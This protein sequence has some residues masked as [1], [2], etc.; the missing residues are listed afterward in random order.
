MPRSA[1][2][3]AEL[4]TEH[5]NEPLDVDVNEPR[6]SWQIPGVAQQH[7]YQIAIAS[8]PSLISVGRADVW[9]SGRVVSASQTD[10]SYRGRALESDAS[11]F[12]AV[13]IWTT[14]GNAPG[15]WSAPVRFETGLLSASD[16]TAK[17]IGRSNPEVVPALGQQSPAPLL[18]KEFMLDDVV[19]R[20]RLRIVGLGYYVAYINGERIGD[21]VLD[22]PPTTFNETALYATHDV[23]DIVHHGENVLAVTLGRGYFGAPR[24]TDVVDLASAP[25]WSEPRL[26]AQ[27]DVTYANGS[28]AR[29]LSDG[30]WRMADGPSSDSARVGERYDARLAP[31][32]WT[33]LGFDASGWM[34][35]PEQPAPTRNVR[36]VAMEPIRIA[37]TLEPVASSSPKPGVTVYDFGRMIAGWALITTTGEAGT[38]ITLK[39]GETLKADGTV[40]LFLNHHVDA[41]TL[42]GSGVETW[43]PSFTRHGFRYI[44][45]STAPVSFGIQ[46]RVNHTDLRPSGEFHSGSDTLNQL[47]A[48]QRAS[49][50]ANMWGFPTD[51]P[52]RDRMGWTADAWL[53]LDSALFNFDVQ[54]LYAQWLRSYRDSQGADG[55]LPMVVPAPA[56]DAFSGP[57][58]PSWSGT[59]VLDAWA[60]YQHYGDTQVLTDNYD[61]MVRWVDL[62]ATIVAAT[63]NIYRGFSFGDWASP[64]T[65]ES[66][67]PFFNA[68]EGVALTASADLYQEARTLA[69]IANVLDRQ[70]DVAKYNAFADEIKAA[71]NATFFDADANVYRTEV[72][73]GYRQTSNLMPLAYGL[74]PAGHEDAVYGN[75]V[76]D[77]RARDNHLNTGAI[78]TKQLLPVL[79]EHGDVDLAYT[80]AT[81]TTYPSWG[82]WLTQG[83]TS[84]WETWSHQ[85]SLQSENHAFLGT[86]DDWLYRYLAGIQAT[87]PG[88]ATV[89]I[90]PVV[91]A[92]LADA[93]ASLSTPRGEVT[94]AWRRTEQGLELAVTI[95]GNTSAEIHVPAGPDDNVVVEGTGHADL[96]RR[97]EGYAVFDSGAGNF[98]FKG[99]R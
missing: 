50:I 61:A 21:R 48:N 17:W 80:L 1:A 13:R 43:E 52:W 26:L 34:P 9:D 71:F 86:F 35:A 68:P 54:R 28:T 36:A 56:L 20:A 63:G 99:S 7:A 44:E 75:L 85:G 40:A 89:R 64:G 72:E 77:I 39:Y 58:D 10:V 82:Y 27:L 59:I 19:A 6:L 32:G 57:N 29:I 23:T 38:M 51:T 76:A 16:W 4:T 15:P 37:E 25:W 12:W 2:Q 95:P 8:D 55:S 47:H 98:T 96:R 60:L 83:A 65:E 53:F 67:L 81:Q 93:S 41:Y 74:V 88:Y 46:A 30:S 66:G 94:S 11:Y 18:R 45:V 97:D 70:A 5:A 69:R 24:S 49:I 91:P 90:K 92:G 87:A 78:G 42:S 3:P 79:T 62:M 22:P 14:E 84:S 73:A 33:N 31:P